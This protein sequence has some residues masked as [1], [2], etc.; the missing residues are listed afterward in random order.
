MSRLRVL[1]Q[2]ILMM[3]PLPLVTVTPAEERV[4]VAALVTGVCSARAWLSA[5]RRYRA[6]PG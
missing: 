6:V 2:G 3:F 4:T 5:D 1:Y